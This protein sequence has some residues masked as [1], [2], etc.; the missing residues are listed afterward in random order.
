MLIAWLNGRAVFKIDGVP[1][2]ARHV[3]IDN[4]TAVAVGVLYAAIGDPG[5]LLD[6]F[7]AAGDIPAVVRLFRK[8]S[9]PGALVYASTLIK[10]ILLSPSHAD[11][12]PGR[13]SA[14]LADML[15]EAGEK[16]E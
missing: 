11:G 13:S 8:S 12:R 10:R 1:G 16:V 6:S 15:Q 2:H 3:H 7:L 4:P 14:E 9:C 5:P